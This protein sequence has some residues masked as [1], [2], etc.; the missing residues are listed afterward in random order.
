MILRPDLVFDPGF[1]PG[2]S[3][4]TTGTHGQEPVGSILV[5]GPD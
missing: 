1:G 4:G 5:L 2:I 3:I